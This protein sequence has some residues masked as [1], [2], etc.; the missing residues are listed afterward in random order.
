MSKEM[1]SAK[2]SPVTKERLEDYAEEIGISRSEA[3]DRMVKQ[4]LDVQESDMELVPI[5][6][7][8]GTEIGNSLEQIESQVNDLDEQIEEVNEQSG[9]SNRL[10]LLLSLAF[11][12]IIGDFIL[13]Y[14]DFAV[15]LS[16]SAWMLA[17]S[18]VY[19]IDEVMP[20]W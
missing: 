20:S 7:D 13:G 8:G 18:Y 6:N 11:L 17:I 5:R 9:I 3:V 10:L 4:G 16:G 14:P 12:W 2:L 15:I 1:V 19:L